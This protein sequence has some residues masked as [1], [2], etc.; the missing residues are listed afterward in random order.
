MVSGPQVVALHCRHVEHESGKG[1][2]VDGRAMMETLT[3]AMNRLRG[4]G[5]QHDFSSTDSGELVCSACGRRH[6]PEDL[7]VQ[8]TVRFEGNSDPDDENILLGLAC[9]CGALGQFSA[10]YGMDTT[11]NDAAVLG[12]LNRVGRIK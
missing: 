2:T 11:P 6:P 9:R 12:R 10:A 8:V 4:D 7:T 1:R 5:Y 3:E